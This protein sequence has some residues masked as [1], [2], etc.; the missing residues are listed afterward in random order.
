LIQACYHPHY[1]GY[2]HRYPELLLWIN[3]RLLDREVNETFFPYHPSPRLWV[4][5]QGRE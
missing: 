1:F 2:L 3:F 5:Q 4:L